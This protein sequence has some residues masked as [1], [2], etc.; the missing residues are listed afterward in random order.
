MATDKLEWVMRWGIAGTF[1]GH[2]IWALSIK[3]SWFGYFTGIGIAASVIPT[4]LVLIGIADILVGIAVLW[5]PYRVL[6][7]WAV[8]WAVITA[9][10]R[11][12]T[13]GFFTIEFADFVERAANFMLPL[14]L[15][16]YQGWPKNVAG[17]FT[18]KDEGE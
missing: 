8:V 11:P 7:G 5:R 2:G 18:V 17:W 6:L 1:I 3:E 16:V 14:A 13:G 15:L 12:I 4:L 10:I 9:L